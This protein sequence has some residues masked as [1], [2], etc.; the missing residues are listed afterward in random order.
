[1]KPKSLT[2]L[3]KALGLTGCSCET[4]GSTTYAYLS[5]SSQEERK[6]MEQTLKAMGYPCNPD[7]AP[8]WNKSEVRV[9]TINPPNSD[10]SYYAKLHANG[11][12]VVVQQ[13]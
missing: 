5:W 9:G 1:M 8:R 11:N 7:Y 10:S 12:R 3:L 4:Y 13:S 6:K 2:R